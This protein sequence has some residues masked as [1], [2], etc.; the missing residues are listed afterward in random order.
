M[1]VFLPFYTVMKKSSILVK[2][3][4]LNAENITVGNTAARCFD[5]FL[6]R[7]ND[8]SLGAFCFKMTHIKEKRK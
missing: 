8:S 3:Q 2:A 4:S 1:M 6:R 7:I 5:Q